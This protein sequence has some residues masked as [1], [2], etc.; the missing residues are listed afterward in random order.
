MVMPIR[1]VMWWSSASTSKFLVCLRC[2]IRRSSAHDTART[3]NVWRSREQS[4]RV[5]AERAAIAPCRKPDPL[6]RVRPQ[7]L[8][9]TAV[10]WGAGRIRS[11]DAELLCLARDR[12]ERENLERIRSRL[13]G[14]L[15]KTGSGDR[16][17]HVRTDR[18][19]HLHTAQHGRGPDPPEARGS[20]AEVA[21]L[22]G[23]ADSAWMVWRPGEDSFEDLV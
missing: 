1:N 15:A 19:W 23:F 8:R 4:D 21:P 16:D 18:D 11:R 7:R 14:R 9:A 22:A 5:C 2:V 20:P 13:C 3:L 10:R 12:L 17:I 6:G